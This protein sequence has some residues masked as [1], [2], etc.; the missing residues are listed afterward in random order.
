MGRFGILSLLFACAS[1]ATPSDGGVFDADV[2]DGGADGE[3]RD[4]AM[5]GGDDCRDCDD[6]DPC[7][8]DMCV[9]A[10]CQHRARPSCESCRSDATCDDGDA[11]TDDRCDETGRCVYEPNVECTDDRSCDDGDDCT[12]DRCEASRCVN[13]GS[14]CDNDE[15]C[16]DTDHCTNNE[17]CEGGRCARDE[18]LAC[19]TC[20]DVDGDGYFDARCGGD[21]CDD[22]DAVRHPHAAPICLG[23]YVDADCSGTVDVFEAICR[24][25]SPECASA[26]RLSLGEERTFLVDAGGYNDGCGGGGAFFEIELDEESDVSVSVHMAHD[27]EADVTT[28]PDYRYSAYLWSACGETTSLIPGPSC[29]DWNPWSKFWPGTPTRRFDAA[30]VPAGRYVVEVRAANQFVELPLI[31]VEV[32]VDATPSVEPACGAA[33]LLAAGMASGRTGGGDG[34]RFGCPEIYSDRLSFEAAGESL[35]HIR[36]ASRERWRIGARGNEEQPLRVALYDSCDG[37]KPSAA[38]VEHR[39]GCAE[40]TLDVI[41]EPGDYYVAVEGVFE[42]ELDYALDVHVEAAGA[43]CVGARVVRESGIVTGDTRGQT[44]DFRAPDTCGDG[45]GPDEVIALEV[46]TEGYVRVALNASA[47]FSRAYLGLYTEC[48]GQALE[49]D[50]ASVDANLEAGTYYVVVDGIRPDDEGAYEIEVEMP[51]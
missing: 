15:A 16:R 10:M 1:T 4:A 41:V 11:A 8:D 30:H 35:H 23:G 39:T 25:T 31:G 47:S 44:D 7:T 40:R 46:P 26:P 5:D 49:Q 50:N 37:A 20:I 29:T 36:A 28:L 18:A 22:G 6:G 42:E 33:P 43:S 12:V 51:R 24:P 9:G 3:G 21:D 32:Q 14:C 27:E 19:M 38:C 2:S 34:F 48:G 17:R 45:A 13:E